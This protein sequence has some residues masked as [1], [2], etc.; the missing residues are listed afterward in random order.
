MISPEL[1]RRYP[2]F[3]GISDACLKSV[4]TISDEVDFA[5]GEEIFEESA[6]F[7]ATS[8][9]YEK[10][11]EANH[12]MLLTEGE[13]DIAFTLGSGEKTVVG[14]LVAGDLMAISALIPP[15]HLTASGIAREAGKTI[16]IEAEG[17]RHLCD[18]NPELGYRLMQSVSKALMRR[19]QSTR[20]ELA[21]VS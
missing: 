6:A 12:L 7:K 15:Y 4:A 20:I 14:T 10:G 16:R 2:H 13:V 5:A 8:R 18:E 3:A 9:L 19:L 17:L 1:L 11:K 21:G